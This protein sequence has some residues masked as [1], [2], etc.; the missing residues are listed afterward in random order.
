M[1]TG[2]LHRLDRRSFLRVT[3]LAGGGML[4]AAYLDP[5][6]KVL[7]QAP[8]GAPTNFVPNAFIKIMPDNLITIISKNPEIGQGVKTSLPMIIAEELDVR[9]EGIRIEQADLDETKYG[10]QNAGGSTATPTNWDPLRQVGASVRAMLVAAAAA[11]WNVPASECETADGRITHRGTNRST[12]YGAVAS[13][14]AIMTPPDMRT[15]PL[16]RASDYRVVGKPTGGIDNRRIV[17]GQPMFGIDFTLPGMLWAVYEK[18]PRVRWQGGQR[19]LRCRQGDA[20]RAPRLCRRGHDR[21]PGTDARRGRGGRQLVAGQERTRQAAGHVERRAVGDA[22]QRG[23]RAPRA[24]DCGTEAGVPAPRRRR[25]RQ[26]I[27]GSGEGLR[28]GVRLPVP[29]ACAAR[30]AELHG[31]LPQRQA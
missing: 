10:R 17:T 11:D 22:E 18:C 28:G 19:K 14:A 6:A 16:K 7:A 3:A 8:Q 23:L 12:T 13:R 30:A 4:V 1:S 15:V 2:L 25:Y 29:L 27:A 5:V 24:R 20:G 9:W 26:G 21:H 31:S